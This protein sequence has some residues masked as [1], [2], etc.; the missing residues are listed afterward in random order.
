MSLRPERIQCESHLRNFVSRACRNILELDF[1]QARNGQILAKAEFCMEEKGL[2]VKK[3]VIFVIDDDEIKVRARSLETGKTSLAR[4]LTVFEMVS[5]SPPDLFSAENITE[6]LIDESF[7]EVENEAAF[8]LE[9]RECA[10][11]MT[12]RALGLKLNNL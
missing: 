8:M 12:L 2:T 4:E 5:G 10:F 6:S 11:E 1:D 7:D 3:E 9:T